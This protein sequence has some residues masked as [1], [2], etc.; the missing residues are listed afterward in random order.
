[1][2]TPKFSR[3]KIVATI[4]PAT[5]SEEMLEKIIEAG[6]DVCRLN[7]SHGQH[8]VL[9]KII[10][11]IRKINEK[12]GLHVCILGDLQGPKLRLGDIE[13]NSITWDKGDIV[14]FTTDKCVGSKEKVYI[15]YPQFPRDVKLDDKILVDDGKIELI[16]LDTNNENEVRAIVT[17]GGEVSSKK[18]VNLPHTQISLPSLTEKDLADLDF[19]LEQEI[20]WIALSFVRTA[21]DIKHL[22][23]IIKE[24]GKRTQVVAKI[25][26]PDAVKNFDS[27][28]KETDGV[29]VARGDLGVEMPMEDV[30]LI[31]KSLVKRCIAAAKPVII[32]TQMMESMITNA[33]PTRAEANDVANAVLDG[34]DAVMLSAETSVGKYPVQVIESMEK[35]IAR[36]EADKT[37]YSIKYS[38]NKKSD[39]FLSDAV[40]LNAVLMSNEVNANAII[41]MTKS[42]YTAFKISSFRPEAKVFIFS[43]DY[44]LLNMLSLVW[45]VQAFFYNKFASTDETIKDVVEI[46]KEQGQ[47]KVGD[48]TINTAS[49][50]IHERQRTNA[51]KISVVD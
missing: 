32:A 41:S 30:P 42:G 12:Y 48:I 49:M 1:L 36:I 44:N 29:M 21:D 4:G 25:E 16:V 8:D 45:G 17:Y 33:R 24:K 40:C 35:I 7:F 31:Q 27:I 46:L 28:L 43:D 3:T 50:P 15:T 10:A 14:T 26:K 20:D 39:S 23:K 18:G 2:L 37:I 38:L 6:V 9:K 5:E 22:K 11:R 51:L 34:A 13:N 19:A 47:L